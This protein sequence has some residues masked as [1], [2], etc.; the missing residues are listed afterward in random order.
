MNIKYKKIEVNDVQIDSTKEKYLFQLVKLSKEWEQEQCGP[1][2]TANDKNYYIGK[3]VYVAI[4][5]ETIIGYAL[6]EIKTLK[7]ETSYNKVGEIAFELDEL[8][9]SKPY[10]SSKIGREL[11]TFLE[12]DLE[13]KV[14]LIGVIATSYKYNEL[15]SFYINALGMDFNHALLVKRV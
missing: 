11:Y 14:D 12:K 13:N 7:E 9:V 3:E 1:S 4:Q 2:Y 5:D 15:L 6:G 8:F 10:R